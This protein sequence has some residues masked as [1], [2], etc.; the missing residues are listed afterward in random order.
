M[1]EGYEQMMNLRTKSQLERHVEM[2]EGYDEL[3]VDSTGQEGSASGNLHGV[4][5]AQGGA[6]VHQQHKLHQKQ[7]PQEQALVNNAAD[8]EHWAKSQLERHVEMYA[9]L[10]EWRMRPEWA[11]HP[12]EYD[13]TNLIYSVT[14]LES[15]GYHVY[16][17]LLRD[18]KNHQKALI[19]MKAAERQNTA[20]EMMNENIAEENV[21]HTSSS[22]EMGRDVD[23]ED[24]DEQAVLDGG[25]KIA[26]SAVT[27]GAR[28]TSSRRTSTGSSSSITTSRTSRS[29][30]SSSRRTASATTKAPDE[31]I[32]VEEV[33]GEF[34]LSQPE[35]HALAENTFVTR[36]GVPHG[37]HYPFFQRISELL[38]HRRQRMQQRQ[39]TTSTSSP[40]NGGVVTSTSS[41]ENSTAFSNQRHPKDRN[42]T[43]ASSLL[44]EEQEEDEALFPHKGRVFRHLADHVIAHVGP[45]ASQLQQ[46]STPSNPDQPHQQQPITLSIESSDKDNERSRHDVIIPK[47]P[48]WIISSVNDLANALLDEGKASSDGVSR[49]QDA[50]VVGSLIMSEIDSTGL[51]ALNTRLQESPN[52][53]LLGA[54][55]QA[56][57]WTS[58]IYHFGDGE[59]QDSSTISD[60]GDAAERDPLSQQISSV[61]SLPLEFAGHAALR[62]SVDDVKWQPPKEGGLKSVFYDRSLTR[63]PFL[64]SVTDLNI[65]LATTE[66]EKAKLENMMEEVVNDR[67]EEKRI[68]RYFGEKRRPEIRGLDRTIYY[69]SARGVVTA[70]HP[71]SGIAYA[72]VDSSYPTYENCGGLCGEVLYDPYWERMIQLGLRDSKLMR[73]VMT[74]QQGQAGGE[75]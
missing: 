14:P 67:V 61:E 35:R 12:N 65:V 69:P 74:M 64:R 45:T 43:S 55:D 48:A 6:P 63:E 19:K 70:R 46:L 7:L 22:T 59:A 17:A 53:R 4:S 72:V 71:T 25:G 11:A 68:L 60:T 44:T 73:K 10:R 50:G 38:F 31:D 27:T 26:R 28:S 56:L 33:F 1:E 62:N 34:S 39:V 5:A 29:T 57:K 49:N 3:E 23:E 15:R 37:D 24:H 66:Q 42:S 51:G 41:Q 21:D 9:I 32:A 52:G 13:L 47:S 30:S 75:Q 2:E 36:G 20:M 40:L 16:E 54:T 58:T 8:Q 18:E